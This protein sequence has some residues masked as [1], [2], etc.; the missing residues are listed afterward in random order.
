MLKTHFIVYG[1][2]PYQLAISKNP[3][4]PSIS[5]EKVPAL[6][7]QPIS[8]IV[9]NNLDAILKARE[10]FISSKNSEKIRQTLSHNIRSSGDVKYISGDSVYYKRIDSKEWHGPAKVLGQD[11]QQVLVKNGSNYIR[12]YPCHT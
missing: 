9:S 10:A 4:L 8:K 11:G 3:K 5:N 1:F 6:T 2:S 12:V 7:H